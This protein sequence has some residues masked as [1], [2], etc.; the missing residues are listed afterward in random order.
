MRSKYDRVR[1]NEQNF[2]VAIPLDLLQNGNKPKTYQAPGR[3]SQTSIITI[4][5]PLSDFWAVPA[6]HISTLSQC[7]LSRKKWFQPL[8]TH[9]PQVETTPAAWYQSQASSI[10][11]CEYV[12]TKWTDSNYQP[13]FLRIGAKQKGLFF[14]FKSSTFFVQHIFASLNP[15]NTSAHTWLYTQSPISFNAVTLRLSRWSTSC[16]IR[17]VN[18]KLISVRSGFIHNTWFR[19][20]NLCIRIR[21]PEWY[22]SARA[23]TNLTWPRSGEVHHD[24]ITTVTEVLCLRKKASPNIY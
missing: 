14:V 10:P 17:I 19:W 1:N 12:L 11:L 5:S 6:L 20:L 15:A 8:Q 2:A 21:P 18:G 23:G 13:W 9:K 16:K 3:F 7:R 4:A 24:I 22:S